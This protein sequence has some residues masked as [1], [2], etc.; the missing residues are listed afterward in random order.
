MYI[1]IK[2]IHT[3]CLRSSFPFYTVSYYIKWVTASWKYSTYVHVLFL[4]DEKNPIIMI[5]YGDGPAF[6]V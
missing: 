5:F 4:I 2:K 1:Q 6:T 3:V